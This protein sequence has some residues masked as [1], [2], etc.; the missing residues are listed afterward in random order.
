MGSNLVKRKGFHVPKELKDRFKKEN[1]TNGFEDFFNDFALN[2]VSKRTKKTYMK[3]LYLFFD[4]LLSC[5]E[6]I[7]RPTDLL[8]CHFTVYRDWLIS[9]EYAPSTINRR[10]VVLRSFT[11]WL[12]GKGLIT[13]DPLTGI[14]FP[15][16]QTITHTQTFS[17]E[18][19]KRMLNAPDPNT[20][21]GSMHRLLLYV[22]FYLGLRR[23]EICSLKR[24]DIVEDIYFF[25]LKVKTKGEKIRVI[26][27]SEQLAFEFNS[28]FNTYYQVTGE[29][30]L[31]CDYILQTNENKKNS[32][33]I[34]PT[35]V[36]RTVDKYVK[37][38]GIKKRLS[39]HSC[40][41]TVISYLLDTKKVPIRDV[42]DF[43]GHENINTTSHYDKKRRA[44]LD[45]AA[46]EVDFENI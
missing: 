41:A 29:E 21:K 37:K 14:R 7:K 42:A 10:M 18:E 46:H 3:D 44:L 6:K 40:R 43:I 25:T 34:S 26:P 33:P 9:K 32:T 12:V 27:L 17:N 36:W 5:G 1:R 2:Y 23:A 11:K 45:S 22:L 13:S 4:F 38:L 30:L 19:V 15:K 24:E 8:P 20:F 35:T 39:P 31:P 28:Y 16:K